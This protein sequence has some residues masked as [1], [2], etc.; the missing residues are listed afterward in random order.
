MQ[1]I[2][3]IS[4]MF[5][6]SVWYYKEKLLILNY[7]IFRWIITSLDEVS[8]TDHQSTMVQ[9]TRFILCSNSKMKCT[10]SESPGDRLLSNNCASSTARCALHACP[11]LIELAY[12][13]FTIYTC[14][15][16]WWTINDMTSFYQRTCIFTMT[17]TNC[18]WVKMWA[19]L[20]LIFFYPSHQNLYGH[21]TFRI[22]IVHIGI[23]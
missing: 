17:K 2:L 21:T 7:N 4:N 3:K 20:V 18:P 23:Y 6:L 22:I 15:P 11:S 10:T 16:V 9:T 5:I 19:L 13:I 12:R 14:W 8:Y 1:F